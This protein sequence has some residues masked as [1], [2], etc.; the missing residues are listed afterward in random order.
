VKYLYIVLLLI[1]ADIVANESCPYKNDGSISILQKNIFEFHN[2]L[3]A[4]DH[5]NSGK[6]DELRKVLIDDIGSS[7]VAM[8]TLLSHPDCNYPPREVL[9]ARKLLK[10]VAIMIENYPIPEWEGDE[11][12][13]V[14]EKAKKFDEQ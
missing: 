11:I 4:L 13:V 1:S 7:V 12:M 2:P 5:F 3:N 6:L 8:D 9:R 10:R 14:L